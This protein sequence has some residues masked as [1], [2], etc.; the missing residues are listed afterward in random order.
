MEFS[1]RLVNTSNHIPKPDLNELTHPAH[2]L[3]DASLLAKLITPHVEH[4]IAF[5]LCQT[6]LLHYGGLQSLTQLSSKDI[7]SVGFDE[8][9][10]TQILVAIE[11]GKRLSTY[12]VDERPIIKNANDAAQLMLDM[13][14]LNQEHIRVILLDNARR[15]IAVPTVYIGTVNAA[16]L[17]TAE[18]YREAIIRNAPALILVHNHPSGD[19]TPSPEDIDLTRALLQAGKLLDI[20]FVDHL[21]IGSEDWCSLKEL[22]L[23]F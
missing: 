9:S 3:S 13:R 10:A 15:V 14:R 17:R 4:D 21:V 8:I 5:T 11:I 6:L 20:V 12:R 16:V 2:T 7:M 18:I 1:C 19:A 22:Q 23:G